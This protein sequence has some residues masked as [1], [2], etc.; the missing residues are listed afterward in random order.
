MRRQKELHNDLIPSPKKEKILAPH[1]MYT[2][3]HADPAPAAGGDLQ[4]CR[5]DKAGEKNV[6]ALLKPGLEIAPRPEIGWRNG[7]TG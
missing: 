6:E 5:G 2:C 7:R 3:I 1:A 4:S